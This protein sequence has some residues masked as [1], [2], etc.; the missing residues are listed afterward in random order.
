MAQKRVKL[1]LV[2]GADTS[3]FIGEKKNY[4]F[5]SSGCTGLDCALGGGYPLGRMTNIVGDK[6]TGKTALGNEAIT[7]F[8]LKYPNGAA[9]Y[10]DSEA[11]FDPDYATAMGMPVAKVDLGEDRDPIITVEDFMRDFDSFLDGRIKAGEP[12]IYV[13]DSMDALSDEAEMTRDIEKGS[14]GTGKAK[15]LSQF[16]RMK[17]RKME[18]A[19]TLLLIVSQIRD[20]IGVFMGEKYKRSGG[21]ALDF[22]A[23]QIMWLAKIKTLKRSVK[24]VERSVGIRVKA[25]LKKNK[26]GNTDRSF[27]FNFMFSYGIEDLVSSIEYMREVKRL[28]DLGMSEAEVKPYFKRMEEMDDAE[29]RKERDTVTPIFQEAWKQVE[30]VAFLP[31]RRKYE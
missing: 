31:K 15:M 26:V 23:S 9:R 29:Y 2:P 10:V 30:T 14:F 7:N 17:A 16:F 12:G 4:Q 3:Y 27:E 1:K 22:Y 11:A 6:S 20:N 18:Q 28:G 8:F 25:Q 19:N 13:V 5:V 21:R 24:G